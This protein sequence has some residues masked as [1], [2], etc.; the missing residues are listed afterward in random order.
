MYCFFFLLQNVSTC[1]LS[2]VSDD[3]FNNGA[4][5][6]QLSE[7]EMKDSVHY[8]KIRRNRYISSDR[9]GLKKKIP[10]CNCLPDSKCGSECLN[11]SSFYEC[12]RKSCPC[13]DK[14]TNTTI[15][16]SSKVPVE[17]FFTAH[18]GW[19]LKAKS[20][21]KSGSFVIEYVGEV[22]SEDEYIQRINTRYSKDVHDYCIYLE[23]GI[24][25][26]AR[27][28]GNESRFINHSCNPN[29]EVQK[30]QINGN[31]TT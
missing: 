16:T 31:F 7:N 4:D 29:C 6:N 27:E 14:C 1:Q 12:G 9:Y 2:I 19:G 25:I 10:K 30:W 17:I 26:D 21:I 11:R 22:M 28:M 5:G 13:G 3:D 23:T 8:K 24:V 15:Q 18:K 20:E